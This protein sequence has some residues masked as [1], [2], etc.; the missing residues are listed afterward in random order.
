M[1]RLKAIFINA[2][3]THDWNYEGQLDENFEKGVKEKDVI[4][5]IVAEAYEIGKDPA[6]LFYKHCPEHLYK[7]SADYGIRTPWAELRLDLDILQQ[8]RQAEF[9]K[10]VKHRR[11]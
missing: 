7:N 3:E 4:R 6:K 9:K 10:N 11:N 1:S 8:E 5:S 2:L